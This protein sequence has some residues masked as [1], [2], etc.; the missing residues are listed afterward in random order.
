M[1]ISGSP[2]VMSP[3]ALYITITNNFLNLNTCLYN[4]NVVSYKRVQF[5]AMCKLTELFE[6]Y[7]GN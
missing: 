6:G 5:T 3:L 1:D 2:V 4:E 7:I